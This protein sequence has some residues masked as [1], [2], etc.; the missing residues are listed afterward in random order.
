MGACINNKVVCGGLPSSDRKFVR[1][2]G[3]KNKVK[4]EVGGRRRM[5][6]GQQVN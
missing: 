4:G 6:R 2:E 3:L 5:K 1:L